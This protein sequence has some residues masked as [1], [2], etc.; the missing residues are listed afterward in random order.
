MPP[1]SSPD[2]TRVILILLAWACV[3][4][5]LLWA[6]HWAFEGRV[7]AGQL[8]PD[9]AIDAM[10]RL[11]VG[12]YAL[13]ALVAAALAGVLW[14]IARD[15]RASRQWPPSGSWPAPRPL[16]D[17]EIARITG[18]LRL[19]AAVAALGGIAALLAAFL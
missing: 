15:T 7:L 3:V 13:G 17:T 6:L 14:R 18:R 8:S 5:G 1:S 16:S 12:L 10:S 4:V 2:R 19:G 11:I 9:V